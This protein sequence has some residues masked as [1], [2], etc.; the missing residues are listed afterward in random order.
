VLLLS[1]SKSSYLARLTGVG[2][3]N[4]RNANRMPTM[5][6]CGFMLPFSL[7]GIPPGWQ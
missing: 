6:H 5:Q 3:S 4:G 1:I 7:A 2:M